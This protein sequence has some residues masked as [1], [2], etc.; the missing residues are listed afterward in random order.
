MLL[1]ILRARDNL[2]SGEETELASLGETIAPNR[3]AYLRE[4]IAPNLTNQSLYAKEYRE[5]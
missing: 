5:R 4:M 1:V 3:Q 2:T